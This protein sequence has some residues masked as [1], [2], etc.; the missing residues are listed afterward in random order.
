MI[1]A[2]RIPSKLALP[3]CSPPGPVPVFCSAD[4][5]CLDALL[6]DFVIFRFII[7]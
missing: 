2:A 1:G 3:G 4:G 7:L 5:L 6:I